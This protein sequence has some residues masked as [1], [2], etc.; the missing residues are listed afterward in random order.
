MT[1]RTLGSHCPD[2]NY[3]DGRDS[4]RA[5]DHMVYEGE[6]LIEQCFSADG[7]EPRE[8]FYPLSVLM[9]H[10]E[11]L[12]PLQEKGKEPRIVLVCLNSNLLC[13]LGTSVKISNLALLWLVNREWSLND[14]PLNRFKL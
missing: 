11:G 13:Q 5:V 2:T 12:F 8:Q 10:R 4:E 1:C 14:G 7:P 6:R 9:L 3:L